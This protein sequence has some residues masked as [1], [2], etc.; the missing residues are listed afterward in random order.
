[1]TGLIVSIGAP[2]PRKLWGKPERTLTEEQ[3]RELE[4]ANRTAYWEA[5]TRDASWMHRAAIGLEL[6]ANQKPP[7]ALE[8]VDGL[9]K[10]PK[11]Q[12][13]REYRAMITWRWE[14][15]RGRKGEL[16]PGW[17]PPVLGREQAR[18]QLAQALNLGT[19]GKRGGTIE[20]VM[21]LI[22]E[23]YR[24]YSPG[25][26][27][28]VVSRFVTGGAHPNSYLRK[29]IGGG[30][31]LFNA[32]LKFRAGP[33]TNAVGIQNARSPY[34]VP[35]V[36]CEHA[37]VMEGNRYRLYLAG[38][39]FPSHTLY[40]NGKTVG[41]LDGVQMT[42]TVRD[43]PLI[44]G[45]RVEN[46]DLRAPPDRSDESAHAPQPIERH[47]YTVQPSDTP[48]LSFDVTECVQQQ[49]EEEAKSAAEQEDGTTGD[50]AVAAMDRGRARAIPLE[51]S[52]KR[53]PSTR[54][55][56]KGRL[57]VTDPPRIVTEPSIGATWDGKGA[58]QIIEK[59]TGRIRMGGNDVLCKSLEFIA[60][61][62]SDSTGGTC[63]GQGT[64]SAPKERRARGSGK[65]IL[66]VNDD[67]T[68]N[69]TIF[70]SVGAPGKCKCN[71][72]LEADD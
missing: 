62:C 33:A 41:T 31:V 29:W 50:G 34:H 24:K 37:L 63:F 18:D 12:Y 70:R 11:T 49:E 1:M 55:R 57:A 48:Y 68:C 56:S 67:G 28:P 9:W 65:S 64:I 4:D 13:F 14:R 59:H 27:S 60:A 2:I 38:S 66:L 30:R 23:Y 42:G 17:T 22:P 6:T 72:R 46:G 43:T 35:W 58:I 53:V 45:A 40:I 39:R 32:V 3:K 61:G 25:E 52:S 10:D 20:R 54:I 36:W 51:G 5:T 8:G 21:G 71:V 15:G 19:K 69:G 16:D 26:K 47:P 7:D 44:R